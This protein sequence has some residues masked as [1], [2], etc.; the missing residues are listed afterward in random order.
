MQY[1]FNYYDRQF[2]EAKQKRP[3]KPLYDALYLGLLSVILYGFLYQYSGEVRHYAELTHAG[4]KFYAIVPIIIAFVFSLV[5]GAF[6]GH[7][8][9]AVGLKAKH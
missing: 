9:E 6:T 3:Y 4:S 2:Q 8:W 1:I 7:F 5:H